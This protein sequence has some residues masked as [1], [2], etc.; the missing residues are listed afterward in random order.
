MSPKDKKEE[1][2]EDPIN[3]LP[4]LNAK[5]KVWKYFGFRRNP[6]VGM[7]GLPLD[8]ELATCRLCMRD[9]KSGGSCKC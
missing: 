6:R 7:E 9:V 3:L 5:S 2:D 4:K 8:R 1:E